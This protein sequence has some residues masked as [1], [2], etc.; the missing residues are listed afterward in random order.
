MTNARI[1]TLTLTILVCLTTLFVRVPLPSRGYFN[2]GDV[3]VIFAGFVLGTVAR[4]RPLVWGALAAGLGSAAAD[5]FGGFAL[6]APLT[7]VAKGLE[8]ALAALA[9]RQ[10]GRLRW[11][12]AGLGG[13]AMVAAYFAGETLMPSIGLQGALAE[14]IPNLIQAVGGVV[15]GILA[16]ALVERTGWLRPDPDEDR[17]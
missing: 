12:W 7:L 8:G 16:F 9:A 6:F 14:V 10:S 5:V 15:L 11:L 4:R 2:V 17:S 13:G 1:L 3:A